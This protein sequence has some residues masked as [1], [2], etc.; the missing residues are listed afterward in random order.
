MHPDSPASSPANVLVVD[1]TPANLRV[2]TR[3]LAR[4]GYAVQVANSGYLA[5][6]LARSHPPDLILLDIMM[7]DLDGYE[8]CDRLK[9]DRETGDIPVIFVSVLNESLN[10]AKAFSVGGADYITKPFEIVEVIARIEHQLKLRSLQRQLRQEVEDHKTTTRRLR[11]LERAVAESSNGIAI[12]DA[13][14]PECPLIYVNQGFERITGYKRE[15]VLGKNCRFLQGNSHDQAAL[16]VL[17]AALEKGESCQVRLQNYRRDGTP[18]WNELSISPVH[19]EAG[20][21]THFI[22]VQTDVSDRVAVEEALR[23]SRSRLAEAERIAHLGYWSFNLDSRTIAWSDEVFRI[24]GLDPLLAHP[25]YEQLLEQTHPEDIPLFEENVR[26]CITEGEPYEHE[27]RIFRPDGEMRHTLGK[28]EVSRDS[29]GRV[30]QIF[31]TVQDITDRKQAEAALWEYQQFLQLIMDSVPQAIFWKDRDLVYLG[32]NRNFAEVAGLESTRDI[33]GKTDYELP[34]GETE[35]DWYRQCDRRVMDSDKAEYRFLETMLQHDGRERW[36]ETSKI[37]LHDTSGAVAGVLG[38]FDDITEQREM[39]EALWERESLLRTL[40]DNLDRG[41]IYQLVREPDGAFHFSYISA[42]IEGWVGVKPEAI[43]EDP[44]IWYESIVEEDRRQYDRLLEISDRDLSGFSMQMRKCTPD[45][46]IQWSGLRAVPRR[47][48]D[49]GTIW[50]GLEMDITDLKQ[51]ERQLAEGETRLRAIFE[52]AAVGINQA[53][54]DSGLFIRANRHFCELLGYTEAELYR[55]TYQEVTHPE[56][57]ARYRLPLARLY[58]QEISSLC[59]E[60]RYLRKDGTPIWTQV[61]LSLIFD[62]EGRPISHLAIVVDIGDRR[63]AQEALKQSRARLESLAMN[64]PGAIYSYVARSP[65]LFWFEYMSGGSRELFGVEPEQVLADPNLLSNQIHPE[66][67]EGYY[68]KVIASMADLTPFSHEWRHVL[69]SGETRWILGNSRPERRE[70]GD[71]VWHGVVLDVSDRKRAAQ[72]LLRAKEKAELASQAKSTFLANMSHELRTPLNAVLGFAQILS[73]ADNLT[74]GQHNNLRIIQRSGEHLLSLIND[75]LDLS[76]I[77][78]GRVTIAEEA[79]DLWRMMDELR[80]LFSLKASQKNL[81]LNC[82]RSLD[83]PQFIRSDRLKLRQILINLLGNAIK[84]TDQGRVELRASRVSPSDSKPTCRLRLGVADSGV[85]MTP[86]EISQLCE[87]FFQAQ[88]GVESQEGTGLG[89][90]ICQKY[91]HLLGSEMEIRSQL[92]EGTAFEFELEVMPAESAEPEPPPQKEAIALPSDAPALALDE[93]TRP[94]ILIVE[95]KVYNRQVLQQMLSPLGVELREARDGLEGIAVW[96]AFRPH[97]IWMDLRMPRADGYEATRMIRKLERERSPAGGDPERTI[98]IALTASAFEEER[99]LAIEAGCDDFLYKPIQM[100]TLLACMSDYL[101]I[102][103]G[104]AEVTAVV[105]SEPPNVARVAS[106]LAQMS[107]R[108]R[109]AL[110]DA[111]MTLNETEM[112]RLV[113]EIPPEWSELAVALRNCAENFDYEQIWQMLEVQTD[114][115]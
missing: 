92:G 9:A 63:R 96:Q 84:F 49:G 90:S 16:A 111:V 89:L 70:N 42:G 19:D 109:S 13:R 59:I 21:V 76:K 72:E 83:V 108:W 27:I 40:G 66:D 73:H 95:D 25:T 67:R 98:I 71:I 56:D 93:G 34:W 54:F 33:V 113:E 69:P 32:C 60:K 43:M 106:Q 24:Y 11:I 12:A 10:K 20:A 26:R 77:E 68:R 78:A 38:T 100:S 31:G 88:A 17:R 41:V 103:Y 61:S 75:I 53:D 85:G 52:Q 45:G 101:G 39:E 62:S 91:L 107:A 110:A 30:A 7:P 74:A 81:H 48:S 97:L 104:D 51:V 35:G 65:D 115:K 36:L 105:E 28:G 2:L 47:R 44:R 14:E 87:P 37:P 1:D 23:E 46:N 22:G 15:E 4:R 29:S 86:E 3:M 57:V 79:F 114:L 6:E 80:D 94:R 64:I 99:I 5:L 58:D 55:K 8:V 112:R 82:V 50:D 18:F 102:C